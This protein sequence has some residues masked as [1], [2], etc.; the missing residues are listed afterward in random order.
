[1]RICDLHTSHVHY[2]LVFQHSYR[3]PG[4][5][6]IVLIYYLGIYYVYYCT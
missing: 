3:Y 6:K 2:L 5:Q 4:I 1:M